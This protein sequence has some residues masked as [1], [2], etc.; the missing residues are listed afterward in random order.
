[1]ASE[2][3]LDETRIAAS[4]ILALPP[5]DVANVFHAQMKGRKLGRLVRLLDRLA[6]QEGDD[7]RLA[8]TALERLGFP[9][10]RTER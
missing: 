2:E 4:E 7:R 5:A 9:V 6:T 10:V 8:A 3:K 1:M